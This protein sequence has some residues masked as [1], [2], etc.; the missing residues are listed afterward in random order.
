MIIRFDIEAKEIEVV[1]RFEMRVKKENKI[2]DVGAKTLP[3]NLGDVFNKANAFCHSKFC[4]TCCIDNKNNN[5]INSNNISN[6]N[7]YN[8]CHKNKLLT[9]IFTNFIAMFKLSSGEI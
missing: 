2:V 7:L 6:G 5:I 8:K 9:Y 1:S 3:I 4:D